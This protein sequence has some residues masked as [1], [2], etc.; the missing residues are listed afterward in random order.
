[1]LNYRLREKKSRMQSGANS[2]SQLRNNKKTCVIYVKLHVYLYKKYSIIRIANY[3][4]AE[5]VDI[6]GAVYMYM[7]KV[8]FR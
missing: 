8:T 5:I 1:M 2:T 3:K 4:S 7:Y 6:D